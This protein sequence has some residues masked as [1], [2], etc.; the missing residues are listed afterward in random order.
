MPA[1]SDLLGKDY[2]KQ[3]EDARSL[4][5]NLADEFMRMNNISESTKQK[6]K[7]IV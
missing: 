4:S 1:D 6:M 2:L 5:N 3:L 7:D